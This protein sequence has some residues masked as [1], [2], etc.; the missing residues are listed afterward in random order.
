LIFHH[1]FSFTFAHTYFLSPFMN[2]V[3]NT[4]LLLYG[5][6]DGIG[7]FTYETLKRI[8]ASHP[9]HD[10]FLVF[11]RK[12]SAEL[13]FPEN[14]RFVI[15]HPQSRHPWL[16]FL[17]F[18][19]FMP[20]LL[21]KLKADLFL[22]PDGWMTNFTSVPGVQVLHDLNF[23]HNPRDLPFWARLYYNNLFPRYARKAARIATVSEFSKRDIVKTYNISPDKI[24]VTPNGCNPDY[25]PTSLQEQETTRDKYSGGKPFFVFVGALIPRKNIARL[26]MAF[27][28][29]KK[30]DTQNI[31]L[32]LIG[33]RKWWTNNI[34]QAYQNMQYQKDVIFISN[35]QKHELRQLYSASLALVFVPYFE[36]FG[37]PI[38]EAFNCDTPVITSNITSMPEVA[39][40]AALQVDPFNVDEISDAMIKVSNDDELR[41]QLIEKGRYRRKLFSWDITAEKLWE[42]IM[43]AADKNKKNR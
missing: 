40:D 3:V 7:W 25:S 11:D 4:Q 8:T 43:K 12:P 1:G 21:K 27:D 28:V 31:Q 15:L 19:I 37:I 6:L 17:R 13:Q 16:W 10:F 35:L 29:F 39:G 26:L 32:V 22:S 23:A 2:I 36:G 42:C 41:I 30:Q 24:D 9:E 14:T 20:F 34:Q 33:N 18:E 38:L 5:K